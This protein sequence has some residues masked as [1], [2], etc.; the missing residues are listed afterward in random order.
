MITFD[1]MKTITN[2]RPLIVKQKEDAGFLFEYSDYCFVK[3]KCGYTIARY[4]RCK[5][6]NLEWWE[7]K[8]STHPL[9]ESDEWH[10]LK[11]NPIFSF[12]IIIDETEP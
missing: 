8:Y 2:E 7:D 1:C 10:L 6:Q 3:N 12:S 5:S 11:E 4:V 9:R